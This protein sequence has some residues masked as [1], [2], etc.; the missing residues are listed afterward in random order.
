MILPLVRVRTST[1]ESFVL[2]PG[3]LIG[4]AASA[5]LQINDPHISEAHA[6]VSLRGSELV[7]LRLRGPLVVGQEPCD[8]VALQA[9]LEIQ[10]SEDHALRVLDVQLP[11]AL[12]GLSFDGA[13]PTPLVSDQHA[14]K[15]GRLV[16]GAPRDADA[17][18][19]HDGQDWFLRRPDAV[20]ER[21][22]PGWTG[23]IHGHP[24]E[25]VDIPILG[26][27]PTISGALV[28]LEIHL[29]EELLRVHRAGHP[30]LQIHGIPARMV[31]EVHQAGP[32]PVPWDSVAYQIW[33]DLLPVSAADE[34]RLKE[35]E[36]TN[37][38]RLSALRQRWDRRRQALKRR[39]FASGV[40]D[41]LRA[42]RGGEVELNLRPE[43]RVLLES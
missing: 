29:Q 32:G 39:L 31:W 16:P 20:A 10:L 18:I 27:S 9:G 4:R 11:D 7:L 23:D 15:D 35:G 30:P 43:D 6:L 21:I 42:V 28:P 3:D 24:V 5:A 33:E 38:Q 13:A 14:I 37:E 34:R 12:L 1:R 2:V 8:Q 40:R 36:L 17:L 41:L 19:W 25:V 22:Q 26:V